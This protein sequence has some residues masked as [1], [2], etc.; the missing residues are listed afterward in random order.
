MH[1]GQNLFDSTKAFGGVEWR[2]DEVMDSLIK[3][4][5]IK[6]CI[7][8]GIWNTQYRFEEYLP[9]KPLSYGDDSINKLLRERKAYYQTRSDAYLKFIVTELK[10][11]ID[12]TYRTNPTRTHT[13]ISGSSMGDLISLYA[14]MEYPEVFGMAA[15][16]STHWPVIFNAYN[17][18]FTQAMIKYMSVRF[19]ETSLR[20]RL[21]FDYGTETLDRY[22]EPEQ[23]MIDKFLLQ[24]QYD[25]TNWITRKFNGA[26]H[27]EAS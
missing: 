6:P 14:A 17:D 12:K 27:N 9:Y 20:P 4:K 7:V 13:H 15:C 16:I 10:P 8:V 23:K 25:F 21:Y 5:K 3:R 1:D 26:A 18:V 19:N 11:Y 2:V 24:Q 22:Y